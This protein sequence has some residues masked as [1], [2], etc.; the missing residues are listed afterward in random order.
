MANSRLKEHSLK[1]NVSVLLKML[2]QTKEAFIS[3]T[4][5]SELSPPGKAD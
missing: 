2:L 1:M 3:L 4:A 5:Q